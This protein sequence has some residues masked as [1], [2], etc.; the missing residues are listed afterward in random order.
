MIRNQYSL[1]Q[2][3]GKRFITD[4]GM[5][6]DLIFNHQIML[7]EF[8]SYNLLRTQNGYET[9]F[10]YYVSYVELAKQ[11][12]L[13]IILETPTWRANTDWGEKIGDSLDSLHKFNQKAVVLLDQIKAEYN[14]EYSPII[15]SGCIGPRGDGYKPDFLMSSTEAQQYHSTQIESFSS[16]NVDMI[17][18]YTI[19]YIEEAIGI[20]LAAQQFNMPVCISF[21][22]ET[23]G[24]LS[25]G[26]T[27]SQ[28]IQSVDKATD[29]GPIYYMINCAHPTHFYHVLAD[30]ECINRLRGV[31]AN[32][33]CCS[34]AD[35]DES[36]E[37]DDGNPEELGK[38]LADINLRFPHVNIIGGC[39]GTDL[40]HLEQIAACCS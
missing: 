11:Y 8:A 9:L 29:N 37:L 18:A 3:S 2:L 6:T 16:T 36:D 25:T 19:N 22:V 23:N 39:C 21:T 7:P 27:L 20:T 31:R 40:R 32:A 14:S 17:S 4:G 33:S 5:E 35:L 15:A 12:K 34:H 10:E 28:A 13:G 1:P 26:A 24:L 30:A 38:Q